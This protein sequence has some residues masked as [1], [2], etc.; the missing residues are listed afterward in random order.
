M[1]LSLTFKDLEKKNTKQ[2]EKNSQRKPLNK[3]ELNI[4]ETKLKKIESFLPAHAKKSARMEVIL[5]ESR[6]KS[7]G[8]NFRVEINLSLPEKILVANFR[9]KSLHAAVDGA[10]SR[11]IRQIR[12]Y[13][14]QHHID[15]KMDGKSL[16]KLR[17]IFRSNEDAERSED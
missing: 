8:K 5:G 9:S 14:T 4:I 16:K 1:Q 13:K 11:M 7:L 15:K 17:S 6:A 12:K 3:N 10:E 2:G